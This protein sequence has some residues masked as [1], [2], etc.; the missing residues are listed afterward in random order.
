MSV[1]IRYA[2]RYKGLSAGVQNRLDPARK[3]R[4]NEW[5]TAFRTQRFRKCL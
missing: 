2:M 4:T 1:A 3:E 5:L